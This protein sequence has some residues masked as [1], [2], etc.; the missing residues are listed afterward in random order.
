MKMRS[1]ADAGDDRSSEEELMSCRHLLVVSEL[2]K[3]T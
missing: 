2:Q 1:P 3:E